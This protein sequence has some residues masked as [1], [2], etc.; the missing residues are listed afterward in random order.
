MPRESLLCDDCGSSMLPRLTVPEVYELL[1][2]EQDRIEDVDAFT[3][4]VLVRSG[5]ASM[6]AIVLVRGGVG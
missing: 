6:P 2:P 1:C 3:D 5:A 4:D